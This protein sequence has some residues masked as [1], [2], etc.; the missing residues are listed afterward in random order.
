M[1]A[2]SVVIQK[3]MYGALPDG[4]AA[5]V[6]GKVAEVVKSGSLSV[7]ATNVNFGD[8]APGRVKKAARRI[9]RERNA[10]QQDGRRK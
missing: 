5:D 6:T 8:P 2:G 7:D 10:R 3:A 9:R 4:P 1:P